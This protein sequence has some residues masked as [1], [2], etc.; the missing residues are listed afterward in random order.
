MVSRDNWEKETLVAEVA[1]RL[2]FSGS[3]I[4]LLAAGLIPAV[5]TGFGVSASF[6][7]GMGFLYSLLVIADE[8]NEALHDMP[9]DGERPFRSRRHTIIWFL[10]RRGAMV[11]AI[12]TGVFALQGERSF[13][14]MFLAGAGALSFFALVDL[15]EFW[16]TI[17]APSEQHP[18][19][20]EIKRKTKREEAARLRLL[21]R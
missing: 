4:I 16:W 15:F 20:G 13:G 5:L 8:V 6:A 14:D 9:V 10:C 11:V 2:G 7:F 17:R 3:I 21:N 12:A 18:T 19:P 1:N